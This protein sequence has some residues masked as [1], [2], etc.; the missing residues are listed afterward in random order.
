[1][2]DTI[3]M[4]DAVVDHPRSRDIL[5]RYP[6]AQIIKCASYT[7]VFNRKAQNFRLQKKKPALILAEKHSGHV[8]P[9]PAQYGIGAEHNYYFSH[10]LNCLY[11]CRYCFLQGMFQSA[12][13]VL[14]VNYENFIDELARLAKQHDD[15]T[16]HFFQVTIVTAWHWTR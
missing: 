5:R 6:R 15:E 7:E 8:L 1:M 16:V 11:D 3:Y 14:F 4:E 9:T 12:H 2:I 10:M 13:Y